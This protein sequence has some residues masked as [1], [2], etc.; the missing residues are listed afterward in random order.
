METCTRTTADLIEELE[1]EAEKARQYASDLEMNTSGVMAS[2]NVALIIGFTKCSGFIWGQGN[3]EGELSQLNDAVVGQGRPVGLVTIILQCDEQEE[4]STFYFRPLAEYA[5]NSE[6][7]SY[8]RTVCETTSSFLQ[9]RLSP[10][11]EWIN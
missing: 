11:S 4:K 3:K 1:A 6:I 7:V 8:L 2:A 10:A 5:D 9:T